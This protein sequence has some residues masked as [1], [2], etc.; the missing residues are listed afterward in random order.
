MRNEHRHDQSNDYDY[1]GENIAATGQ[2]HTNVDA[3][4]KKFLAAS[5][6]YTDRAFSIS[7][8]LYFTFHN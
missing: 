3:Y 1:V 6:S 4:L 8:Q 7:S 5:G 2:S